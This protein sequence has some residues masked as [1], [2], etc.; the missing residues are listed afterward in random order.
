MIR[1]AKN[2]GNGTLRVLIK[3][4][5]VI[6]SELFSVKSFRHIFISILLLGC[7]TFTCTAKRHSLRKRSER[8][9]ER[10]KVIKTDDEILA[11][12]LRKHTKDMSFI[13][14]HKA[15]EYYKKDKNQ[16]MQIKCGERVLA[17]N[18]NKDR[19]PNQEEI[20]RMTRLQLAEIFLE[21][22]S[23]KDA[24]RYAKEYLSFYPGTH[25]ALKAE[26]IAIQSNFLAKLDSDRDQEKTRTALKLAQQFM[27]KHPEE[28]EYTPRIKDMI[29]DCY[30]TLVRNEIHVITTQLHNYN[31]TGF[32]GTLVAAQKRL[33][34][35]KKEYM[36][37]APVTTKKVLELELQIAQAGNLADKI[38]SVSKELEQLKARE[39]KVR[40]PIV[41]A[42]ASPAN[43]TNFLD[44]IRERFHESNERYFA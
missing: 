4:I 13:E 43:S 6:M 2:S 5:E 24:E 32:Q 19:H 35:I 8:I 28:K 27:E 18:G 9:E 7:A 20:I 31:Y 36:P 25:E 3:L 34:Y 30:Q 1:F 11:T 44:S 12:I 37:H 16:D 38:A 33:E 22:T 29:H 26:F 39:A 14:A 10:K 40:K 41:L 42:Q 17:A 15:N 21:R 23:Y